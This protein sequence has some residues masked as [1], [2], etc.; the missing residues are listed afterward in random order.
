[1]NGTTVRGRGKKNVVEGV[2]RHNVYCR[3]GENLRALK[4][5]SQCPLVLLVKVGWEVQLM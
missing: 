1:M 4:L 5:P 2:L 3:K